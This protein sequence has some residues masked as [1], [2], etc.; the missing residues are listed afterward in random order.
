[1][2]GRNVPIHLGS[3]VRN[4]PLHPSSQSFTNT[5]PLHAWKCPKYCRQSGEQ[6][7][8]TPRLS[9]DTDAVDDAD[10]TSV[11]QDRVQE[12]ISG[13]STDQGSQK[14]E[15]RRRRAG[16]RGQSLEESATSFQGA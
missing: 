14:P 1:M 9:Q 15:K 11:F 12:G 13:D 16:G 5:A 2:G 6:R 10:I 4:S 8:K 7:R 3:Q